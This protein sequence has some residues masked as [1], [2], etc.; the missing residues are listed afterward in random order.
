[1]KGLCS[2]RILSFLRISNVPISVSKKRDR[3]T[4]LKPEEKE[5]KKTETGNTLKFTTC[6]ICEYCYKKKTLKKKSCNLGLLFKLT[7]MRIY[8]F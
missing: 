1:M 7:W 6:V 4:V 5:K 2:F 8:I 3:Q